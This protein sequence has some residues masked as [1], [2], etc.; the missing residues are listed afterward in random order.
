MTGGEPGRRPCEGRQENFET[1][2]RSS[3]AGSRAEGKPRRPARQRSVSPAAVPGRDGVPQAARYAP[4][5]PPDGWRDEPGAR[6]GAVTSRSAERTGFARLGLPIVPHPAALRVQGRAPSRSLPEVAPAVFV[7]QP[8]AFHG[9]RRSDVSGTDQ[10]FLGSLQRQ[11]GASLGCTRDPRPLE[12]R[13]HHG[14]PLG[15]A[16][17]RL[18]PSRPCH[19]ST[20]L[21][22]IITKRAGRREGRRGGPARLGGRGGLVKLLHGG[23]VRYAESIPL[24]V[25]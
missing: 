19:P 17:S 13:G 25:G 9:D 12:G 2:A 23:R 1:T 10:C 14:P 7:E 5:L 22:V 18:P 15:C 16:R 6:R 11:P 3:A 20:L 21:A 4:L 24:V 8:P